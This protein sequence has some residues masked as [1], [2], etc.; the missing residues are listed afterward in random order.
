MGSTQRP[1][2]L[3]LSGWGDTDFHGAVNFRFTEFSE[4][5]DESCN[6]YCN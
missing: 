2:V 5:R 3:A 1:E 4:V 6:K